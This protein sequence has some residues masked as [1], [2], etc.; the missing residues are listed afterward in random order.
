MNYSKI[1][2]VDI[3]NGPG[4]RTT[5]W[6]SGCNHKCPGCF[7]QDLWNFNSGEQFTS[8]TI[9]EVVEALTP[10]YI[11]GLSI[12]GGE[13][14]EPS[15]QQQVLKLIT[16]VREQCT[17][18]TI[19]LYTGFTWEQLFEKDCRA[20]TQYLSDILHKIDILVDGPYQ[21]ENKSVGLPFRGSSNQ[22]FI[23]VALT[24]KLQQIIEETYE[25]V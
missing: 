17:N 11:A 4:C 13:P 9:K 10:S 1:K 22:R 16:A 24:L 19:W 18:K 2:K 7:N 20:N 23:K 14:L 25:R 5:I 6:V 8:D 12:L 21:I 15:N 3:A